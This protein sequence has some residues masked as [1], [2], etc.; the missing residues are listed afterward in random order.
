MEVGWTNVLLTG[1][2]R[3]IGRELT[4]QLVG[5]GAHIIAMG[6]DAKQLASSPTP[7]RGRSRHTMSTWQTRRPWTRRS[8]H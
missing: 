2:A 6:R 1:A 3:G 8:P 7:I 4:R 5:Q